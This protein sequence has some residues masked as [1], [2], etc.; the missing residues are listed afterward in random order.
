[1]AKELSEMLTD[2][3]H[4]AKKVED[5]FAA[6][7]DE[8]DA[9]AEARRDKSRAAATDAVATMDQSLSSAGESVAGHWQAMNARIDT[10]IKGIQADIADRKHARDV[11]QAEK[12]AAAAKER[13]A[14]AVAFA[15]VALQT[16]GAAV[17]DAAVAGR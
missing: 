12:Q 4:Q 10:E 15:A 7:A 2:L 5:A 16:A 8:T 11:S 6:I 14:N 17:L 13:A 1:M 9:A 3:S